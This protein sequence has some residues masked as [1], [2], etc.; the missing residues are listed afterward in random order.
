MYIKAKIRTYSDKAYTNFRILNVPEDDIELE[1][2]TAISTD[3][4]LVYANKYYLQ[5]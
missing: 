1:S 5:V 3:Y 4:L 2:F